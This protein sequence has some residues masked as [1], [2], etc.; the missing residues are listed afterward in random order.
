MMVFC[1]WLAS[2]VFLALHHGQRIP[3]FGNHLKNLQHNDGYYNS[4]IGV[5]L[6]NGVFHVKVNAE[7]D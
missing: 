1:W 5:S 2:H 3:C 4:S 7:Y 6:P